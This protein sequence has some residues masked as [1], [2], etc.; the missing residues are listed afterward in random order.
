MPKD[1][2]KHLNFIKP[3]FRKPK[4]ELGKQTDKKFD[5]TMNIHDLNLNEVDNMLNEKEQSLK[6][7]IFDLA[8][9]EALVHNDPKLS[10]IY[11]E[12]AED[13]DEKYG[14]HYN[15]TI[16]NL[17]FNDYVLNSAEY[18]EKYKNAIPSEKK[19]RDK[20]GIKQLQD[21]GTKK[22]LK[23]EK[24][25]ESNTHNNSLPGV[26]EESTG[27]FGVVNGFGYDHE[28]DGMQRVH[29]KYDTLND[30]SKNVN[31][32][33][34]NLQDV[35]DEAKRISQ[36][37]GV[38][39]HVNRISNNQ[40]NISD[41]YDE[42]STV[43]SYEDGNEF[44][45]SIE[46]TTTTSSAGDYAYVGPFRGNRP[47]VLD[48][49]AWDGGKII[50]ESNY[51]ND[52]SGFK[53]I[54]N[55]LNEDYKDSM[56]IPTTDPDWIELYSTIF[57]SDTAT[58]LSDEEAKNKVLDFAKK[59][60]VSLEELIQYAKEANNTSQ[61]DEGMTSPNDMSR[62][63]MAEDEQNIDLN[64]QEKQVVQDIL[65]QKEDNKDN[66]NEH[67]AS[68]KD[69][70]INFLIAASKYFGN[71][72][73]DKT[74]SKFS[75]AELERLYNDVESVLHEKGE[76][77]KVMQMQQGVNEGEAYSEDQRK[78]AGAAL[79]AKRGE[80][81][82]SEL[83]GASKDMYDS[84]SE[85]ELEDMASGVK[86]TT[87][88]A[89]AGAFAAPM[90]YQ[91]KNSNESEQDVNENPLVGMA[92]TAAG[93]AIGNKIGGKLMGEEEPVDEDFQASD[94]FDV[95][96]IDDESLETAL[97]TKDQGGISM[98]REK[99]LELARGIFPKQYFPELDLDDDGAY[100]Q[101]MKAV[102]ALG[103]KSAEEALDAIK[104]GKDKR[105]KFYEAYI[106]S[107]ESII[108]DLDTSIISDNPTSMKM[109]QPIGQMGVSQVGGIGEDK[110]MGEDEDPC[111]DGYDMV[112]TKEKDG[113]EVP[114][115]VP[116]DSVD[117]G[118]NG[119]GESAEGYDTDSILRNFGTNPEGI[120]GDKFEAKELDSYNPNAIKPTDD[121]QIDQLKNGRKET[122]LVESDGRCRKDEVFVDGQCRK[123]KTVDKERLEGKL[124]NKEEKK[125]KKKSEEPKD[126]KNI[127]ARKERESKH[128]KDLEAKQKEYDRELEK[129]KDTMKKLKES[130]GETRKP[131]A[132]VMLDRLKGENKK[133]FKQ[134]LDKTNLDDAVENSELRASDQYT[135][136]GENPYE[137]GEKIEKEKMEQ[138]KY[139]SFDNEGNSTNRNN[140]EIPKRN[141]SSDES[142]QVMMDRG[143]GMHDIVYDNEPSERF[144]ER[145]KQDMGEDWY[146]VR[147][148]KMDYQAKAPMYN[149]DTQPVDDAE[150]DK[151]Q[152]NKYKAG[153]NSKSGFKMESK[154]TE[155]PLMLEGTF[156]GKY[157]DDWGKTKYLNFT[158]RD[159]YKLDESKLDESF[160]PLSLDG[161]G[162]H[163]KNKL[164]ESKNQLA[165]NTEYD[166]FMKNYDLY[167]R[168]GNVFASGNKN[169]G[170]STGLINEGE[171]KKI[172]E[173]QPINEQ[174]NKMKHL[175]GYK[176]NE[177][178]DSKKSKL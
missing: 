90:G 62:V 109:K 160:T 118:S 146:D 107:N 23:K 163:Y 145:M 144:E 49:P 164:S 88:A 89:S 132:L 38:V 82:A 108:D 140:K 63:P 92:A 106:A 28:D 15:E 172:S 2:F 151:V 32:N 98:D 57:N 138:H 176:P 126:Q 65:S 58:K 86:E 101:V 7:K 71:P 166:L 76:L 91:R 56:G 139:N 170:S 16:M 121:D 157:K 129:H 123:K 155:K 152:Y 47:D 149:K 104:S 111:W 162:N 124:D 142:E 137:L 115:C 53:K 55:M 81:E 42:D 154:E 128:K 68:T 175:M 35:R 158:A 3:T 34:G 27:N 113:K 77:E 171:N 46:E 26:Q 6:K 117:E 9:M 40:Y 52:P 19:R 83:F 110:K 135:E 96:N 131:S 12:M 11:N 178:I 64:Q 103:Y 105:I 14:Y 24:T 116:E 136:V 80:M 70:M 169:S 67:H 21:K 167:V 54:F 127:E 87:G 120:D 37:E 72:L 112:G 125:T 134:D 168:D 165:E 43:V 148:K 18:L 22:Q 153:Y 50:G 69:E 143:K 78:A 141:L 29:K 133:N 85:E 161:L 74:L 36:E 174:F 41:F 60:N 1:E 61:F 97:D 73:D 13:G 8:K 100:E 130:L 84:M 17:I 33:S 39:Q 173:K 119:G 114:N 75:D 159:I 66:V 147:Q 59:E 51:L 95:N 45:N 20:T 122:D 25:E 93:T 79:A 44:N 156:T 10:A 30:P 150:V 48:E 99:A 31:E 4:T 177:Y 102:D 5:R 94:D